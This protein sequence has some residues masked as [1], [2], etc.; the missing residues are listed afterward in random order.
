MTRIGSNRPPERVAK[1]TK[2]A[3]DAAEPGADRYTLWDSEVKGFGL[4]VT[5]A[6]AKTYIARYRTGGGRTGQLR[7]MTLGRHGTLT[8]EEARALAKKTLGAVT[9]GADPAAARAAERQAISVREVAETFLLEHMEAKRKPS[10]TVLYR[11]ILNRH[12]LPEFGGRKAESL[13][14]ADLAKLHIKMRPTRFQAN[15][16]LAVVGSMYSFAASRGFVAKGVNPSVGIEKYTEQGRERY[17]SSEELARLGDAIREAETVGIPWEPDPAKKSK[18]A[19]KAENRRTRIDPYAAAALR[20]LLLTGARLREI[21]HLRWDHVDLERG[22]LF[23]PDSKTGKKTIVLN[24][25]AM[26]LLAELPRAGAFVIAGASAGTDEEKPRADLQRPWALVSRRAGFFEM[27]P[28]LM[29]QGKPEVD[30]KGKP[31]LRE[32]PTVRLHD[33]RHT[34]A[35]I[36]AGAGLGLPVIGK[37]LGHTQASTTQRYAHLDADPLRRA[38]DQIGRAIAAAM[39]EPAGKLP[40]KTGRT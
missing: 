26:S 13:T 29:V 5:P 17:L 4:R 16:M 36:G 23:L 25:P 37:L 11:D 8:P 2:R 9:N 1:L 18:H 27:T 38:S 14:S 6:G 15:R 20:L 35:S 32:R 24:G 10:T 19:P 7:Q 39:G 31:K 3:V 22:L 12:V 33:L 21:L 34:H 28:V 30:A 40:A